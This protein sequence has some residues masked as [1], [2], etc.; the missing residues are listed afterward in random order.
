MTRRVS[1]NND[2]AGIVDWDVKLEIIYAV[3]GVATK[4]QIVQA[5]L[6]R[7]SNGDA[8]LQSLQKWDTSKPKSAKSLA[9]FDALAQKLGCAEQVTGL[10][11]IRADAH[12]FTE[13][14]GQDERAIALEVIAGRRKGNPVMEPLESSNAPNSAS[15][16]ANAKQIRLQSTKPVETVLSGFRVGKIDQR[17]YYL[18]PDTSASWDSLIK[19]ESY[20]IFDHCKTSLSV[21]FNHES[22][23]KAISDLKPSTVVMLAGG[24]APSKDMLII[25]NILAQPSLVSD[26]NYCILDISFYMLRDSVLCLSEYIRTVEGN[27]RVK[28]D[29]IH[30]DIL[31]LTEDHRHWFHRNGPVVFG[32]TGV[33]IGNISEAAFF[34]SLDNASAE[35][36]LLFISVE[37]I[38]S[39]PADHLEES[40]TKKYNSP[41]LRRLLHPVIRTV[42]SHSSSRESV[43]SA[44]NRMQVK[45]RPA[46]GSHTSDIPSSWSIVVTL[47]VD[48]REV[49]LVSS[50]R[51]VS[52]E[53]V[54]FA[55]RFGWKLI[56][57]VAPPSNSDYRQFLF[58]R[59]K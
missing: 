45:L 49:T 42:L 54:A 32:V 23:N 41:E 19:A 6:G 18:D 13:L 2:K 50:A 31:A 46:G 47:E 37:T 34:K 12:A 14:L 26:I 53:F 16:I 56:D 22:W 59:N 58:K 40:L 43:D 20:P 11:L 8:I 30:E 33:T 55:E 1:A 21:L 39:A 3:L 57:Q 7:A 24:G 36:D 44:L 52:A 17:H 35:G 25:R 27:E 9:F 10:R 38:D 51:Y 48:G 5:V 29:A 28:I 4:P 15:R